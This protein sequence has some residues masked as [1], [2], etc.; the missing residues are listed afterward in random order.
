MTPATLPD[1]LRVLWVKNDPL[2]PLDSGGRIRTYQTLRLWHRLHHVTYLAYFPPGTNAQAK[3]HAANYSTEQAWVSGWEETPKRGLRFYASVLGNLLF[4]RFPYVI[5][6][7]RCDKA[8]GEIARLDSTQDFD[9]V[10]ADFLSMTP[11]VIASGIDPTKVVVFQHN[12]ESLIWKRHFVTARNPL[13]KLL[14]YVQWRRFERYERETCARFQGVIA[15]SEDDALRFVKECGLRN[16][17]GY[18]P[19]GVDV[20]YFSAF[21]HRPEPGHLVFL[22]SMDWMPNITG[23]VDFVRTTWPSIKRAHPEAKL[24]IVGRN[25]APAVQALA[26]HDSSIEV[27][28]TVDDVR[29]YLQRAAV[30]IVPLSVGGGTRIKIFEAMAMG[31]PVVSTAVGAEGL[32][33]TEGTDILIG[34][35]PDA[36]AQRVG[37]LL[38]DAAQAHAIGRAGQKLVAERFSWDTAIRQFDDMC[39]KAIEGR[40]LRAPADP[41]ATRT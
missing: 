4:S 9:L 21:E 35:A 25:P 40:R 16:V 34:D 11:N 31:V 1:R 17:L 19:T 3:A 22:G 18:V 15:V 10:I 39:I 2:F 30:S 13:M 32:P 33:V 12:V 14:M 8:A 36:F 28:G 5:D 24:T 37:V 6:K 41:I 7:Y 29:P 20:D 23:I 38:G 26:R 27:T